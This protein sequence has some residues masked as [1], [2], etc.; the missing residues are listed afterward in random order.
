MLKIFQKESV[1]KIKSFAA[2]HERIAAVSFLFSLFFIFWIFNLFSG[3]TAETKYVLASVK[4]GTITVSVSGSGQVS[5][6]NEV[7]LKAKTSSDV[8]YVAV[9]PGAKMQ[10]GAL[11][12]SLD[13]SDAEKAVRDAEIDL[14]TA[15]LNLEELL[16]PASGLSLIQA[17][18]NLIKAE[19]SK[20]SAEEDLKK[21]YED[22]F[23]SISNTF[24][25]LPSVMSGLQDTLYTS[26]SALGG[27][28]QWNIDFYANSAAQ[29]D[30][31]ADD[32]KDDLKTKHTAAKLEYE[33][34]SGKYKATSRSASDEEIETL[35]DETYLL[36]RDIS[37]T[38]KSATNLIQFY[39]EVFLDHNLTPKSLSDTHLSTLNSYTSE[40]NSTLSDLLSAKNSIESA[41]NS[42][43][44]AKRTIEESS[45][46]LKEL[47]AGADELE[48]RSAKITVR[49]KE[50][51]LL[52]AKKDLSSC[53]IRAPFNGTLAALVIKK[54]DSVSSGASIGTFI[55]DQ[56]I[57]EISLN[58]VDASKIKVG[59]KVALSFDAIDGLS[60]SGEVA[61][62][63][64]IGSVSQGVVSYSLKISFDV[65]DDRVKP[66]MSVTASIIT[67]SKQDI[68]L[69]PS[70][71]IKTEND[72]SYV[73]ILANDSSIQKRQVK[74]GISDDE[75][76]E[77]IS[78]LSE[79]EKIIEKTTTSTSSS[80]LSSSS[81]K[82]S[83]SGGL[84]DMGGGGPPR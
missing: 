78:G 74:I 22:G 59:N 13:A 29:F 48:I 52:D 39:R 54:G 34:I 60:L 30:D 3:S 44:S 4:K 50:N 71:A 72:S 12:A 1:Q 83:S 2:A 61:E 37:E 58:E 57:A 33:E 35:I 67:D 65:Q 42:I 5:S 20:K 27:S 14:E 53:Y 51:D 41:K 17:E 56:K 46:S 6:S 47:K 80:S 36:T 70:L 18:N 26:S 45:E 40:V 15:N 21:A 31:A 75:N 9:S 43:T 10:S 38:V 49:Q 16:K 62:L 82:S 32:Y 69:A 7:D 81:S 63:D 79:N 64:S 25:N 66:G 28:S 76:T 77:I 8:V 55:A 11:I 73:E 68:L 19:E 24:L 84:F 23:T